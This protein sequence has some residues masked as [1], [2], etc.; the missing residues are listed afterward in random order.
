MSTR[1]P[2]Q[3]HLAALTPTVGSKPTASADFKNAKV[4]N[5]NVSLHLPALCWGRLINSSHLIISSF[6]SASACVIKGHWVRQF[7]CCCFSCQP[8]QCLA[9]FVCVLLYCNFKQLYI[10]VVLDVQPIKLECCVNKTNMCAEPSNLRLSTFSIW[11]LFFND[12]I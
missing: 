12:S 6:T 3:S 11:R 2:K 5:V 8:M 4:M 7:C 1:E 10:K 9:G